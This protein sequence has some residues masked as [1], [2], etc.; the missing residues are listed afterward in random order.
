MVSLQGR[1]VL[2][3]GASSGIGALTAKLLAKR[4]AIP[5]LT[6]R[7][8]DKLLRLSETIESDH[9]VYEMDVSSAEQVASVAASVHARFGTIDI[10]LNN[11]GYGEFI[12]FAEAPLSHFEEMM[13]VNYMGTVRCTHAVLPYMLQ[14]GCGHIVNVASLAGKMATAKSTGYAATK[15]AVLGFT[16]ALRR[17]LRGSGIYVS[18][19]NPGPIDTPFFRRADPEGTYVRN[20][21]KFILQPDRVAEAIVSVMERR[22]AELDM[23]WAAGVGAKLAQLFPRTVDK[24]FGK[25]LNKK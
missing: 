24:L 25:F 23:P 2:I 16:N 18:A 9:E 15:H 6:A 5:V 13:D 4:G 20:V 10:L 14:A 21:R 12:S 8:R 7:S 19:V 3:T 17:E 1:V 22:T 11:A